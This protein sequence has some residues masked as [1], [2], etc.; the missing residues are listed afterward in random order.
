MSA[1]IANVVDV[2]GINLVLAAIVMGIAIIQFL[3]RIALVV[4]RVGED[5]KRKNTLKKETLKPDKITAE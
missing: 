1:I 5:W 4:W 2:G 3:I